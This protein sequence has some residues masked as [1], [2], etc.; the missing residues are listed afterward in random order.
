[1]AF[2]GAA[3]ASNVVNP[4]DIISLA[5]K[6]YQLYKDAKNNKED[7]KTLAARVEIV[8]EIVKNLQASV[9]LKNTVIQ[10]AL[11]NLYIKLTEIEMR[12]KGFIAKSKFKHFIKSGKYKE[13]FEA[14]QKDLLADVALLN[15]ALSGKLALDKAFS[16]DA[17]FNIELQK[18]VNE[19][20]G[21]IKDSQ[22]YVDIGWVKGKSPEKIEQDKKQYL[23]KKI[24]EYLQQNKENNEKS[25][26][27]KELEYLKEDLS[28]IKDILSNNQQ[29]SKESSKEILGQMEFNHQEDM[30]ALKQWLLAVQESFNSSQKVVQHTLEKIE[31]QGESQHED[32]K[33]LRAWC[34][35][36]K[37]AFEISQTSSSG[38]KQDIKDLNTEINGLVDG[39]L[40][41]LSSK[42]NKISEQVEDV[43]QKVGN[44][45]TAVEEGVKKLDE[46]LSDV[47]TVVKGVN[48]EVNELKATLE[49]QQKAEQQRLEKE[50]KEKEQR[51]KEK[52]QRKQEEEKRKQA[53]E[54][55]KQQELEEFFKNRFQSLAGKVLMFPPQPLAKQEAPKKPELTGQ[56]WYD[57]GYEARENGKYEDAVFYFKQAVE[58][59]HDK[60]CTDLGLCY[61]LGL[62]VTKNEAKGKELFQK[63]AERGHG[64]AMFFLGEILYR[65]ENRQGALEWLQ[66]AEKNE[67]FMGSIK[68]NTKTKLKKLI[69]DCKTQPSSYSS[70]S[71]ALC[72]R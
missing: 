9:E 8:G 27:N 44:V 47:H 32:M 16:Q 69:A 3:A 37:A 30:E 6:I 2:I 43:N 17:E 67:E 52:E 70:L 48:N 62:G 29:Q 64:R 39:L 12:I 63:G 33:E 31:E 26:K 58:L 54:K 11:S 61:C 15:L 22:E 59:G 35:D 10:N 57:Q 51:R 50:A 21:Q 36:I 38:I 25:L 42:M 60:A 53:E 19:Y 72:P 40:A 49:A 28:E 14:L 5:K 45:H 13:R 46:E 18:K 34:N 65:E 20:E 41:E 24:Q 66:K 68:E 4:V 7:Y 23:Q 1:M 71:M 56:E 55:K